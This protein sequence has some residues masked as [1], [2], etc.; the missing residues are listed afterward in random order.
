MPE[1]P[2][3]ET[4]RRILTSR[5]IGKKIINIKVLY[6]RMIHNDLSLLDNILDTEI[7]SIDRKGKYLIFKFKN[8]YAL[9]SHLRMEGKYYFY[10]LDE[11]DS[12]YA[13]VIFYL[14][15]K[16]KICYDDSRKFGVMKI[17]K[18]DQLDNDKW[19]SI[20]G[21]E[22]M[23][24][25]DASYL[26]NI[27]RKINKPIKALLLDQ[28]FLSGLGNIYVDETLFLAK[29]HPLRSAKTLSLDDFKNILE[30]SKVTLLKA[31]ELGGSTIKSYHAS[32]EVNGLFQEE[33]LVY[34][35]KNEPCPSCKT[36]LTK[37]IVGGRGTTY[38][39]KCQRLTDKTVIG[40]TGA[41]GSGKSTALKILSSL[42]ADVISSDNV[43]LELYKNKQILLDLEKILNVKLLDENCVFMKE[44]LRNAITSSLDNKNKLELY[45]YPLVKLKLIEFINKSKKDIIVLEVP[46]LFEAHFEHLC[47]ITIAIKISNENQ[48]SNLSKR[49]QIN[50]ESMIKMNYKGEE[51]P[52]KD[53]VTYYLDTN[54][55]EDVLKQLLISIYNKKKG[56]C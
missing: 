14:D 15:S 13:R 41:I 33:L 55:N 48:Y 20:L 23:D 39:E 3:V 18:I 38:C 35:K 50:I 40:L 24:V 34:G 10:S 19:L 43:V 7:T 47:N 8:D 22:P 30:A 26:Y 32:R 21:P 37:I 1:L 36:P 53:K 31:I 11:S 17:V 16:E 49:G 46:L 4:I 45:L 6:E 44:N 56:D 2:E 28:S 29:I 27:A 51:Y 52:Y 25:E 5:L 12:K 9:I 54:N 42:G